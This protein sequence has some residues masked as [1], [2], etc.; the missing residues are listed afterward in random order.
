MVAQGRI[1]VRET[2]GRK[3]N[4]RVNFL[5]MYFIRTNEEIHLSFKNSEKQRTQ[6]LSI[7]SSRKIF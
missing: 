6:A 3:N 2:G 4:C 5:S 7:K 1:N